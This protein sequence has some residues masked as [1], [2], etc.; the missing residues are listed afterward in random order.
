[1]ELL[2]LGG[3]G[4]LGRELS[5]QAVGRGHQVTCFARGRSGPVADGA[6]LIATDRREPE[7]YVALTSRSWD[8][9]VEVSWQPRLVRAALAALHQ[10]ATHWTYVSSCSVYASHAASGSDETAQVLP[11]TD[12]D[13]VD[14]DLYGEAKVACEE[15][16][17]DTVGDR[18]LVARA[19]LI[20]GPGDHTGRS[21][22]WV[23]RAPRDP[24]ARCSSLTPRPPRLRWLTS[25]TWPR[26]GREPQPSRPACTTARGKPYSP[27]CWPGNVNRAWTGHARPASPRTA[28]TSCW[29]PCL[30]RLNDV[31]WEAECGGER[32]RGRIPCRRRCAVRLG[33]RRPR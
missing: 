31:S 11:A 17:R 33:L 4:W 22:Y 9:V 18:L 29:P 13:D 25:G 26:G 5:R 14:R 8:A 15:A 24:T 7:A 10:R 1:M 20:G 23:A 21:G 32:D 28:N 12:R 3:T 2:V 19:G 30:R 6:V 16:S 27:T